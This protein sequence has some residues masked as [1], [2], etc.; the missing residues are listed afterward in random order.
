V[1]EASAGQLPDGVSYYRAG[2]GEFALWCPE[3][4]HIEEPMSLARAHM[5]ACKLHGAVVLENE[6]VVGI[7]VTDGRVAG[8]ET[9]GRSIATPVVVDAAGGWMRQV[10][11]LAEAQ[12]PVAPVRHRLLITAP[13]AD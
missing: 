7:S 4:V 10:A 1:R 9:S 13:T 6:P 3:D 2:G 11:E 8:V 5:D 12:V